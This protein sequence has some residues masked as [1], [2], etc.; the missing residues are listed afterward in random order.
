MKIGE[1]AKKTGVSISTIRFYVLKGLLIPSVNNTKYVFSSDDFH[2]LETIILYK[3]MGFSI[4]EIH[5]ILSLHR[6]SIGVELE[7]RHDLIKLLKSKRT[8]LLSEINTINQQIRLLDEKIKENETYIVPAPKQ[9]G[10]PMAAFQYLYCPECQKPL[11]LSNANMDYKYIYNGVLDCDCGYSAQIEDGI[12][13]TPGNEISKYDKPDVKRNVYKEMPNHLVTIFKKT[14]KWLLPKLNEYSQSNSVIM[15]THL[16]SFFFLYKQLHSMNPDCLYIISDKF[17]D[18]IKMYKKY[19]EQSGLDL[20]ILYIVNNN[21]HF[22][23]KHGCIDCLIDYCSSNEH[24]IYS[25]TFY[26]KD[27]APF[28]RPKGHV[29]STYFSF[30]INSCSIKTLCTDYPENHPDNYKL[31]FFKKSFEK[32]YSVLQHEPMG[33]T[34]DSGDGLSFIFHQNGEKMYINCYFLVRN[35]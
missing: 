11:H 10:V 22:P 3:D 18:V 21:N 29:L 13:L 34:A 2:D 20:N 7:D 27:M 19:I 12:V 35:T 6:I 24:N 23:L 32:D 17:V 28:I 25:K 15:E 14:Y 9:T 16:N 1:L 33:Y 31:Y 8:D 5:R 26:L 30:D 4:D